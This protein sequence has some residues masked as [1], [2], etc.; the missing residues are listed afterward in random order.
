MNTKSQP[1]KDRMVEYKELMNRSTKAVSQIVDI[2]GTFHY[3][4]QETICKAV[5]K[6]LN[7][8]LGDC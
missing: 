2:L 8:E 1:V 6:I 4:N 3:E 7:L 5:L